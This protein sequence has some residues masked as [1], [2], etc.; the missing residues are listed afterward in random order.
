MGKTDPFLPCPHCGAPMRA[1]SLKRHEPL[2]VKNPIAY[3]RYHAALAAAPGNKRGITCARYVAL[4]SADKTLP[5]VL[6]LRRMCGGR[7]W[8]AILAAF[9]LESP[10]PE[11]RRTK[12]PH[13]GKF[14]V[15]ANMTEHVQACR[16]RTVQPKP[17]PAPK[18]AT[19]R[20]PRIYTFT[21]RKPRTVPPPQPCPQCGMPVINPR[22][23]VC[24]EAP[25]TVAWLA[26]HLPDPADPRRII[27]YKAYCALPSKPI[28][29]AVLN[30]YMGWPALAAR[31][32]LEDRAAKRNDDG[33]PQ[34][35]P[36][37][38]A[39]LHRLAWELHGGRLGP[40]HGE[41]GIFAEHARSKETSLAKAFGGWVNVLAAAGLPAGTIGD[42]IRAANARRAAQETTKPQAPVA[43]RYERGDEPIS[44]ET[45]GLPVLDKPRQLPG[46]GVAWMIR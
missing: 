4:S 24:P 19:P 35:D 8:D 10:L 23:H 31:Y 6:T 5:N 40:S 13:C 43:S 38:L 9:G 3:A 7:S 20:P 37:D 28:S 25:A 12:C 2:C 30:R 1:G 32:G 18:P 22:R 26:K 45:V 16:Q 41:F 39:E 33:T 11:E 42:Y 44:R 14:V 27:S 15:A 46:G 17:P 34:L 21:P 29:P 36:A